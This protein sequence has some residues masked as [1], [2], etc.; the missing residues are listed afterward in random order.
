MS[1]ETNQETSWPTPSFH[2]KVTFGNKGEMSFQEVSGLDNEVDIIEYR[3]GNSKSFSKVKMPD[4]KKFSDIT[5]KRGLFRENMALLDYFNGIHANAIQRE[6]VTIQLLDE[7]HQSLFTWTLQNAFP[8][9]ITIFDFNSP[10]NEVAID[11]IM[12]SHEG[13]TIEAA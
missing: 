10:N 13:L 1:N 8:T 5:L 12:L 2:F 4:L 11:E 7:T 3:A 9:K 6:T